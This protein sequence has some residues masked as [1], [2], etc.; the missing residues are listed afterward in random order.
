[1]SEHVA[2]VYGHLQ[3]NF[4]VSA[5]LTCVSRQ[6]R[7]FLEVASVALSRHFKNINLLPIMSGHGLRLSEHLAKDEL[8]V[9]CV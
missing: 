3:E 6:N 2:L 9:T 4:S 8:S 5:V 7:D 1:V